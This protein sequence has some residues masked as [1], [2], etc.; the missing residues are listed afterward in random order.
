VHAYI[1]GEHGDSEMAAWSATHIAGMPIDQYCPICRKCD[2]WNKERDAIA[3]A[4]RTSAYHI[5]DYKGATY[6][7]VG[8]ALVR[9]VGAILRNERSVLTV[10][11]LL[12]GEYG[13][14]N[15]C[16]SLP[17]IV[18]ELG[19]KCIIESELTADE[20]EGLERSAQVLQSTLDELRNDERR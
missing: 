5:I 7:A 13:L 12:E 11:S 18:S 3:E 14:S 2:D 9:I 17:C 10:S 15:V 16:L 19:V 20:R 4:V 1:L 6:F 8:L